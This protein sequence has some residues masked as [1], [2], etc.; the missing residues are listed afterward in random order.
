M[1][2]KLNAREVALKILYKIDMN[3]SYS[4]LLLDK[5][6]NSNDLMHQDK[7]L[8]T[9]LT[10]GVISNKITLDY[11]IKSNSK[12]KLNKISPWVINILRLGIYQILY[13]T[14][15]PQSAGV[16]ESVKLTKKY[17]NQGAVGFVNGLLRNVVRSGMPDF[18]KI[19]DV[20]ERLS[21]K[22][23]YPL[24]M[25]EKWV[26]EFGV[27]FTESLLIAN[28][29]TPQT[30][31]RVNTLK[32]NKEELKKRLEQDNIEYSE[33]TLEDA[34]YIKAPN[35]AALE[36]FK[37]GLFT[38]QDEAAMLTSIVLSPEP[39]EKVLDTCS[40]PGG[41]TTHIAQLMKNNGQIIACEL[42]ENRL[43]L[44]EETAK[45]LG[46]TIINT[47]CQ[48]AAILEN[49][50][51]EKFDR[52][53]VDAPCSGLGVIRRKPD[54]KWTKQ[55]N[56]I[57]EIVK[58]QKSILENAA[59]Y[60]R[61]EGVLIYST[62]T[63]GKEENDNVVDWFLSEN[64]DFEILNINEL[65]PKDLAKIILKDKMIKI[66]PNEINMDGFFIC[67]MKKLGGKNE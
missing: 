30:T 16:N 20:K 15:I 13:L 32:T 36:V 63:I 49:S 4:N 50:F 22:Y 60:V 55:E 56:D 19:A 47:K 11:I 44:V 37:E 7:A 17:S 41:K 39:G 27:E 43:K 58:I 5:E 52:V 2:N 66:Y 29:K 3:K 40:A 57:Q 38:S 65:I 14:K 8:V 53:I 23:S 24:W 31:I 46:V 28:N 62:C 10:Y 1:E 6:L 45:R 54:I 59:L 35:I 51:I 21:I 61:K 33:G 34:L 48:D 12:L 9:Q 26:N 25:I 64:K 18:D 42:Y 67:A